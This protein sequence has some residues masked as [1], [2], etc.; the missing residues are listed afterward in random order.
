VPFYDEV[1]QRFQKIPICKGLVVIKAD[2][3][4]IVHEKH[5]GISYKEAQLLVELMIAI[6]KRSLINGE[7][8]KL[9]GFGSLNVIERKA[10]L[11]R[12]PHTGDRIALA[13]SKY[14]TFRPSRLLNT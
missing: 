13:A 12:N 1:R 6:M 3:A 10:R 7:N 9:T 8:V 11:G 5:G 2:L 4:R 14:I